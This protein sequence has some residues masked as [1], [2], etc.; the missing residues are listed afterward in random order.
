MDGITRYKVRITFIEE[1]LGSAP[2]NQSVYSPYIASK[3][4]ATA[5][6]AAVAAEAL[7]IVNADEKGRT[8]FHRDEDGSPFLYDYVVRG[9]MKEA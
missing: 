4:P 2:L 6:G 1:L 9:F 8:G 7:T 5:N 3:A